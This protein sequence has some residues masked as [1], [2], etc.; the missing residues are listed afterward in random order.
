MHILKEGEAVG[1]GL[2]WVTESSR[3]WWLETITES[4]CLGPDATNPLTRTL[5]DGGEQSLCWCCRICWDSLSARHPGWMEETSGWG[6][7]SAVL[8]TL[9]RTSYLGPYLELPTQTEQEL[10][11]TVFIVPL[12]KVMRIE[13]ERC[14]LHIKH[15]KCTCCWACLT[16]DDVFSDHSTLSVIC[17]P[18]KLDAADCLQLRSI[19]LIFA[20]LMRPITVVSSVYL[21]M[22]LEADAA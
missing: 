5:H 8:T 13:E 3:V 22:W 10:V 1:E 14:V 2:L 4:G 19:G 7:F 15:R 21:M 11:G 20:V 18:Q 6:F 12:Q 17:T 16:S 9:C